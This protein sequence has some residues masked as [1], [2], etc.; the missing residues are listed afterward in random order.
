MHQK[1]APR[2]NYG[3]RLN[4]AFRASL[5]PEFLLLSGQDFWVTVNCDHGFC[6]GDGQTEVT[7]E[8]SVVIAADQIAIL[9]QDATGTVLAP[10]SFCCG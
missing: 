5:L 2:A 8:V 7:R 3:F 9:I 1:A 6:Q 10:S 4:L